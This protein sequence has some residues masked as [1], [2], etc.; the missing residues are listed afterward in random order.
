MKKKILILLLLLT[1]IA[2]PGV[3]YLLGYIPLGDTS[4]GELGAELAEGGEAVG[5][6]G[7]P[8]TEQEALYLALN[9][10]FVVNFTHLGT[11]R[12]LQI[13]LEIMYHDQDLL[14]RVANKMPAV[15]NDLILLLSNQEY[16]K[17]NSLAGKEEIRKEMMLA[18]NN[19]IF[20]EGEDVDA[21]A[22]YF[23]NFIMQ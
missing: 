22:I 3:L 23:T 19:L 12:Y 2:V 16:E 8:V 15:R 17:L 18:V 13:S 6:H 5:E 9:P 1:V 21:G 20:D 10:P 7:N 11:L 14:D 4:A